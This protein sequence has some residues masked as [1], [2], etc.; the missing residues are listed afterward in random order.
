[1]SGPDPGRF[2][3]GN[4]PPGSYIVT[5]RSGPGNQEI[6]AF[7]RIVLR[8]VAYMPPPVP[9]PSYTVTLR[10]TPPLSVDGRL[11]IQSGET[12]DLR[13]ASVGLLSVDP[14]LPSPRSVSARTDGQFKLGGIVPSNYVVDISNLPQD[15]Y[16]KAAR[17][18]DDDI[19]EKPLTLEPKPVA[20]ALQILL[21]SDGGRLQVAAYNGNGELQP[22]ARF[23]LVPDQTRRHRR[24][25]YRAAT[26]GEDGQ[27]ILRGIPPG[28]YRLFAW[29]ELE[30]NAYLNSDYLRNYEDLG[31]PVNIASGDNPPVSARL[32]P[33]EKF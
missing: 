7:Q 23:V 32:I 10:L 25:Q 3:L 18:G 31:V 2:S 13:E 27:A 14:D 21:G 22:G 6:I 28:S 1:L 11:F 17:F 15:L 8:P 9:P 30:A 33:K 12:V 24:E 4:I 16:L 19:L 26:S 29:E 5:A 20:N